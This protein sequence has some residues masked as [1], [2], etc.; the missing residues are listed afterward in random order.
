[1]AATIIVSGMAIAGYQQQQPQEPSLSVTMKVSDWNLVLE[2]LSNTPY[3][4]S[5][6]LIGSITN[7]L[8]VQL[9]KLDSARKK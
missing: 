5:A 3:K 1:M 2:S 9:Q 7:Q 6:P 4:T 8:Q